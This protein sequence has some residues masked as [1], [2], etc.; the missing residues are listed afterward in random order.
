MLERN[1]YITNILLPTLLDM[2]NYINIEKG[3][4][5]I[6]APMHISLLVSYFF[7]FFYVSLHVTLNLD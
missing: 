7:K 2:V 1:I 5:I 4:Y 3:V 6:D